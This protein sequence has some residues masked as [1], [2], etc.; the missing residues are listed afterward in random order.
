[1][2]RNE[3]MSMSMLSTFAASLLLGGQIVAWEQCHQPNSSTVLCTGV[4]GDS[5]GSCGDVPNTDCSS[6]ST[7]E[8]NNFPDGV[9]DTASG[10][11]AQEQADCIKQTHCVRDSSQSP[12]VCK[13][14]TAGAWTQGAKTIS[15][16]A[17]CP[18]S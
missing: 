14:G 13:A 6:K 9:V 8:I 15:G 2:R 5:V 16:T 1:M 11:T 17:T 3:R 7:Y 18:A 12:S 4:P 10:T